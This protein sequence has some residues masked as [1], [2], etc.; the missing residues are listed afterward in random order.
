MDEFTKPDMTFEN[1]LRFSPYAYSK[2]IWMKDRGDTEVAGYCVTETKDPLLVTDFCLIKQECTPISF[3][4]DPDDGVDYMERMAMDRGLPPWTFANILAHSHPG[5]DPQPSPKDEEN[6]AKAFSHPY[7]AI[8]LIVAQD[9]SIYCRIKFNVG[10]GG[11]QMLKV[12]VDFSQEFRASDH[13][14]WDDEYRAKVTVVDP[15][16]WYVENK[17]DLHRQGKEK[18]INCNWTSDGDAIYWNDRDEGWYFYN[19]IKEKWYFTYDLDEIPDEYDYPNEPWAKQ[20]IEWAE[21]NIE[22]R[23]LTMEV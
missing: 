9:G 15:I 3:D 10:P 12:E 6:F 1:V 13:G 11:T 2:L 5:K 19:P 8:M 14:A 7:W 23:Q 20:V 17:F 4:L 16:L 18:E 22:Y 21:K